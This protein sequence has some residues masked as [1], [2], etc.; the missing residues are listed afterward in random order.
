MNAMIRT[1]G[2]RD[3]LLRG[4]GRPAAAAILLVLAALLAWPETA[5]AQNATGLPIIVG[6]A[7]ERTDETLRCIKESSGDVSPV[8]DIAPA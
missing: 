3:G 8:R 5:R 1:Q 4:L 2:R 6:T 7:A